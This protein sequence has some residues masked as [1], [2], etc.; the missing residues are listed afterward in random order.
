ML[1]CFY[2]LFETYYTEILFLPFSR[3][4]FKTVRLFLALILDRNP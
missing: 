4:R 1:R 2:A 3:R